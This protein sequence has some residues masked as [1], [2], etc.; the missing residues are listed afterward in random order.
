M[1]GMF[2]YLPACAL[3]RAYEPLKRLQAIRPVGVPLGSMT[4]TTSP[5]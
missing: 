3:A 4:S 2:C 1:R 5:V